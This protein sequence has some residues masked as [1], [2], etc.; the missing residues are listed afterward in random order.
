MRRNFC[1][2]MA[3]M[4]KLSVLG[5]PLARSNDQLIRRRERAIVLTD[6]FDEAQQRESPLGVFCRCY[7]G[8]RQSGRHDGHGA[9]LLRDQ[10]QVRIIYE[11]VP[12]ACIENM[13]VWNIAHHYGPSGSADGWPCSA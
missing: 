3:A 8:D 1:G 13:F 5:V 2:C 11:V 4:N 6:G 9:S 12:R 7:F 10:V